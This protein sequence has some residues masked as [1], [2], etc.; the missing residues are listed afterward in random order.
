[1]SDRRAGHTSCRWIKRIISECRA[2]VLGSHVCGRKVVHAEHQRLVIRGTKEVGCWI[3]S[4]V[5]GKRPSVRAACRS[6]WTLRP[7]QGYTC[8]PST[9]GLRPVERVGRGVQ[10]EVTVR[11]GACSRSGRAV[12]YGPTIDPIGTVRSIG[13]IAA[14]CSLR[15]IRPRGSGGTLRPLCTCCTYCT[16]SALRAGCSCRTHCSG[17]SLW[18]LRTGSSCWP[19]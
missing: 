16:R 11:S 2:C 15:S 4:C 5:S 12:Q 3:R 9:T 14:G 6:L 7:N 1:M 8:S 19:G 18:P 10:V 13:S 17:I